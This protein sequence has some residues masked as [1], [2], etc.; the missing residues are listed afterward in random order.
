MPVDSLTVKQC[1]N[2]ISGNQTSSAV[3]H[4]ASQGSLSDRYQDQHLKVLERGTACDKRVFD[5]Q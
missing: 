4:T 1:K 2:E 3:K 5:F